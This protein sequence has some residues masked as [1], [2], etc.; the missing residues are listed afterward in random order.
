MGSKYSGDYILLL[1]CSIL[2]SL[3]V[4]QYQR[5]LKHCHAALSTPSSTEQEYVAPPWVSPWSAAP[6]DCIFSI[7]SKG[8]IQGSLWAMASFRQHPPPAMRAPPWLHMEICSAWCPW[9]AGQHPTPLYV[10]HALWDAW[11]FCSASG[12]SPA[13]LY[14]CWFL[15]DYFSFLTPLSQLL[16]CSNF[17]FLQFVLKE[18]YKASFMSKFC[19]LVDPFWNR[20][21]WLWD[22][23]GQLLGSAHRGHPSRSCY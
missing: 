2:Y 18:V 6:P 9:A 14:C 19:P 3:V 13:L 4:F 20:W 11:N 16:F 23:M 8:S 21:N 7:V 10:E 22:D 1:R 17:P 5:T 12:A 15:Q